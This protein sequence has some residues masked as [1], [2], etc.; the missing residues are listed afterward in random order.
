MWQSNFVHGILLTFFF[1]QTTVITLYSNLISSDRFSFDKQIIWQVTCAC[2]PHH[3]HRSP[4]RPA[5]HTQIGT[6]IY[7]YSILNDISVADYVCDAECW[8]EVSLPLAGN[9]QPFVRDWNMLRG[10]GSGSGI[11]MQRTVSEGLKQWII[12][13]Y[14][15]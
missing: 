10:A 3:L 4:N 7:I 5:I 14:S 6:S 9:N 8:G 11:F 13:L 12:S 15:S 2:V 1:H